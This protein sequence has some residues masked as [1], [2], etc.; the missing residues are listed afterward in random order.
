MMG[1][2]TNP[3]NGAYYALTVIQDGT[4]GRTLTF[5]ADFRF[6]GVNATQTPTVTPNSNLR[7]KIV[8]T[9]EGGLVR[10]LALIPN[11]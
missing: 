5:H 4:G 3:V 1:A 7:T 9:Y 8:F 11:I 10:A 6:T 2:P